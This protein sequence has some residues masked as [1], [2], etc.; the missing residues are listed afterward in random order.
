MKE[1]TYIEETTYGSLK[2]M[3]K[4][5][6]VIP[7]VMVVAYRMVAYESFQLESEI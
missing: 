2:T 4:S 6:W 3:R 5:G 7:K 1:L